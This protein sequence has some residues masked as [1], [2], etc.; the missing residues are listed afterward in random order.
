MSRR[1]LR[2]CSRG[3]TAVAMLHL[4][5][6]FFAGFL[7]FPAFVAHMLTPVHLEDAGRS[8]LASYLLASPPV[9]QVSAVH[10][11]GY[12]YRKTEGL[13]MM[14]LF[15]DGEAYSSLIPYT[16]E[17][18]VAADG[19]GRM[20]WRE[21]RPIPLNEE[22]RLALLAGEQVTVPKPSGDFGPG[23]LGPTDFSRFYGYKGGPF[24]FRTLGDIHRMVGVP[25]DLATEL[26]EVAVQDPNI[27]RLG[28]VTDRLGRPGLA[29]AQTGGGV[30]EV[31][32]LH[33][34]TKMLLSIETLRTD[35][36]P[37]LDGPYPVF[38]GYMT[39]VES[40]TVPD[41]PTPLRIPPGGNGLR[42]RLSSPAA[43]GR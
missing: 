37:A 9:A 36:V 17:V 18:W 21:G 23:Q 1:S 7:T 30:R 14:G 10:P 35:P 39:V 11:A 2:T 16:L 8:V 13:D 40:G 27:D 32:I 38:T 31:L 5:R 20:Q 4:G 25:E 3:Y 41:L 22:T 24:A 29:L 15:K 6:F 19:S 43:A 33:P 28:A 34:D 42:D 12:H 26:Y